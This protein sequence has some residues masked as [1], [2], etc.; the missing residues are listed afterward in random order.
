MNP[1]E[2]LRMDALEAI[3]R[4]DTYYQ[5]LMHQMRQIEKKY[6][7]VLKGFC[8]EDRDAVGEFVSQCEE[9]SWYMLELACR[10]M[11]FP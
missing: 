3:A 1:E 7:D 11:R 9:I 5:D 2:R 4:Q 6:H 8:D 10:Y